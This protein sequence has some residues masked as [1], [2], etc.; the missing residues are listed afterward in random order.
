MTAK[1]ARILWIVAVVALGL[2]ATM[3]LLGGIGTVC[4]AFLTEEF[5]P[6][7]VLLDHQWLY[8]RL[9]LITIG[10]G[11]AGAWVTL[12]LFR[13]GPSAYRNAVAVLVAGSVLGEL[14][15]RASLEL[16]GQMVPA[17]VK[18]YINL[19]TLILFLILG[20]P[21]LRQGVSFSR[22]RGRTE[23][24]GAGGLAAFV[25]GMAMLTVG[26]W[27]GSSHTYDGT[28]WTEVLQPYLSIAGLAFAGGGLG[29]F[30]KAALALLRQPDV[31]TLHHPVTTTG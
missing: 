27:V 22:P 4:A 30:V 15:M 16:R 1:T 17:N 11:I 12:G 19:F 14:H 21:S 28:D 5:P 3:N 6:M 13:G 24:A 20:L 29:V 18:F 8:Q 2:T 25:V 26:W 31:T 23:A 10:V 7:R 9:M